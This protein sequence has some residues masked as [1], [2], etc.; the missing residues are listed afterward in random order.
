[1]PSHT[2]NKVQNFLKNLFSIEMPEYPNAREAIPD[3]VRYKQFVDTH[4]QMPTGQGFTGIGSD[5]YDALTGFSLRDAV[6]TGIR[7]AGQF[8]FPRGIMAP[9]MTEQQQRDIIRNNVTGPMAR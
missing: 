4:Q 9:T 2:T 6:G 8:L 7:K 5:I 1:M 3:D